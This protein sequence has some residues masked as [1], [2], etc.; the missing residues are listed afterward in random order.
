QNGVAGSEIVVP[1]PA[2]ILP[3]GE[4]VQCVEADPVSELVGMIHQSLEPALVGGGPGSHFRLSAL[5]YRMPRKV[6]PAA[7]VSCPL[8]EQFFRRHARQDPFVLWFGI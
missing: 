4:P 7:V 2:L 3:R 5:F 8:A 1:V 6:H